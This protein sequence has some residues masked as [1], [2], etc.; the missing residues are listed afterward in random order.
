MTEQ[1]KKSPSHLCEELRTFK[2][3]SDSLLS[4][5]GKLT[6]LIAQLEVEVEASPVDSANRKRVTK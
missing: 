1:R 3:F 4:K 5:S 2:K 6:E